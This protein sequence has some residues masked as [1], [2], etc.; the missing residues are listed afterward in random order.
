MKEPSF[1]RKPLKEQT[2]NNFEF[3]TGSSFFILNNFELQHFCHF[4]ISYRLY[5]YFAKILEF[6]FRLK[7]SIIIITRGAPTK[8]RRVIV[9]Q[10][11]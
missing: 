6:L 5:A 7:T 10:R 1:A 3:E 8:K 2:V 9:D 4:P 11:L